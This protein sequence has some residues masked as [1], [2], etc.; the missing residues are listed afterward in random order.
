[1]SN[2]LRSLRAWLLQNHLTPE[3]IKI[4]IKC[5]NKKVKYNLEYLFWKDLIDV[6]LL[7]PGN[8]QQIKG[9]KYNGMEIT[10]EDE[11]E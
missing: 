10:I 8:Y 1:M 4:V 2:I 11:N 5:K 7:D 3:D 6:N 9:L